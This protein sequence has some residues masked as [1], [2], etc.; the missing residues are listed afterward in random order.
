MS[1]KIID[2]YLSSVWPGI[3][4]K[5]HGFSSVRMKADMVS[6]VARPILYLAYPFPVYTTTNAEYNDHSDSK[7]W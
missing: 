4:T 2:N 6:I 1:I 3:L 7:N 5:C